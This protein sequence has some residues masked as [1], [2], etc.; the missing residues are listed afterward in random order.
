MFSFW[1]PF[2][3]CRWLGSSE[4]VLPAS[5]LVQCQ[6][7]LPTYSLNLLPGS[8]AACCSGYLCIPV[9]SLSSYTVPGSGR[10]LCQAASVIPAYKF[11]DPFQSVLTQVIHNGVGLT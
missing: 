1:I 9:H 6:V 7:P 8:R 11:E 4:G 2:P 3:V 5:H 10:R